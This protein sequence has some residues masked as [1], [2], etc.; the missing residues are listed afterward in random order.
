MSTY[1]SS[2]FQV[3]APAYT[4]S[5]DRSYEHSNRSFPRPVS[6]QWANLSAFIKISQARSTSITS[7]LPSTQVAAFYK[8]TIQR[9]MRKT[10]RFR[11]CRRPLF[12]DLCREANT[13]PAEK[14][15]A[16]SLQHRPPRAFKRVPSA[17]TAPAAMPLR[18]PCFQTPAWK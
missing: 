10:Q 11:K 18:H 8:S 7:K 16:A 3:T 6:F 2:P 15:P 9:H 5:I 13:Q 1:C 14:Y 12:S 4:K 17:R